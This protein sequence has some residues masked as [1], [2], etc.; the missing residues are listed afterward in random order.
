[1]RQRMLHL[2]SCSSFRV[3]SSDCSVEREPE[4]VSSPEPALS[5]AVHTFAGNFRFN[6]RELVPDHFGRPETGND[7]L[8]AEENAAEQATASTNACRRQ[9]A[10]RRDRRRVVRCHRCRSSAQF[11]RT[12]LGTP[13]GPQERRTARRRG[14]LAPTFHVQTQ[15]PTQG[16]T[17]VEAHRRSRSEYFARSRRTRP[18]ARHL[19]YAVRH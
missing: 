12:R 1:M 18:L 14:S 9:A 17:L 16:A 6:A 10:S 15:E 5:E 4:T 7:R 19:R 3:G 13:S 8:R 11:P 2:R